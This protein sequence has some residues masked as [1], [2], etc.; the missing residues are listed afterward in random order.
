MAGR[1]P[2]G[3]RYNV[4]NA[5]P[6]NAAVIRRISKSLSLT[7][8]RI[9]RSLSLEHREKA[10]RSSS[11]RQRRPTSA[12]A[13]ERTSWAMSSIRSLHAQTNSSS[14]R[15]SP[16]DPQPF[17]WQDPFAEV[18]L[19]HVHPKTL[20]RSLGASHYYPVAGRGWLFP[21]LDL[22]CDAGRRFT[23]CGNWWIHRGP[24]S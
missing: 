21:A 5:S 23:R 1:E 18:A 13:S 17:E 16:Q 24:D 10:R 9:W 7:Y 19:S 14:Q 2:G 8:R 3:K 4:P 22:A 6:S 15:T 11:L 12:R 20:L